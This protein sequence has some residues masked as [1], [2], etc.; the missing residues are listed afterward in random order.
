[1]CNL[2][3]DNESCENFVSKAL[4]D[5]SRLETKPHLHPYDIGWINKGPCIKVIDRCHVPI[6][7]KKFY[8]Y[9]IACDVM[10]MDKCHILLIR[11]WQHDIDATHKGR[12]NMYLFT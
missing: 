3:I 9:H 5:Y 4:V 8:Q 6:S 12:D 1:V 7:I 2:I 11:P 10:D